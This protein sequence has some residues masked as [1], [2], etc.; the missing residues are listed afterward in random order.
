[1]ALSLGITGGI[2]SG[3]SLICRIFRLLGIPVFEADK[4]AAYMMDNDPGLIFDLKKQFGDDI[5][6]ENN[7]LDRKK[8]AALIFGNRRYL[9]KVNQ[10]VHP[11]VRNEFMTW[12]EKQNSPYLVYEAAI[13]F[14]SGFYKNLDFN[15][16]VTAPEE[17]K[18]ERVVQRDGMSVA[19]IK[20]RMSRQWTDEEKRK[21]ADLEIV[22]DNK[23]L[24]I[25]VVLTIDKNLKEY[26][27]IW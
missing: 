9:E 6:S 17:L 11:A 12:K 10:L 13:L 27:K 19:D 16:L 14:E 21:S 25:P 24:V 3:K 8:L 4:M 1:M 7:T 23:H 26:G 5:Y 22:N 2:G 20:L 15:I 18:I